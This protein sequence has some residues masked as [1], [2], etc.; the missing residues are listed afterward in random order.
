MWYTELRSTASR[1]RE[2]TFLQIG[3]PTPPSFSGCSSHLYRLLE[4]GDFPR[5]VV[6]LDLQRLDVG[7]DLRVRLL[8]VLPG[9]DDL[10]LQLSDQHGLFLE[11][12]RQEES[13]S[14]TQDEE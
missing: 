6:V 5:E 10:L 1:N 7:L 11:K 13:A 8:G 2:E 14:C 4:D 12:T 3:K 9:L